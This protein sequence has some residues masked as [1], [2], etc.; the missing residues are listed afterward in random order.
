MTD[1]LLPD[2]APPRRIGLKSVIDGLKRSGT[3]FKKRNKRAERRE[4]ASVPTPLVSRQSPDTESVTDQFL[5]SLQR[6]QH[7]SVHR[8][9]WVRRVLEE[10]Q[11][12]G[13]N[14]TAAELVIQ[15]GFVSPSTVIETIQ[16]EGLQMPL[17]ADAARL[18]YLWPASLLAQMGVVPIRLHDETLYI[19]ALRPLE[20]FEQKT[21]ID[22]AASQETKITR[23]TV[24]P[25]DAVTVL[26][27]IQAT[28]HVTGSAFTDLLVR[29]DIATNPS[30]LAPVLDSLFTDAIE[31]ASSD[32]HIEVH[33]SATETR[34]EY[35]V[36][37][38]L[39]HRANI[40][41]ILGQRIA[42]LIRER[43][44]IDTSNLEKPHDGKFNV[45]FHGRPIDI[46]VA[47]MPTYAGQKLTLRLS[48]PRAFQTV[49]HIFGHFPEISA[50]L[51]RDAREAARRGSF[52][53]VTGPTNQGKSTTLR[54]VIM[55]MERES[56]R[57][58]E[59]GD[60]IEVLT[61][62]TTQTNINTHPDVGLTYASYLKHALRHDPDVLFVQELRDEDTAIELL[63][64]VETGH[65]A[66]S[67]LHAD[68]AIDTLPRLFSLIDRNRG[69]A[70]YIFAKFLTWIVHQ[71]LVSTPCPT[72]STQI[73]ASSLDPHTRKI[74]GLADNDTV[75]EI[76][77]DGCSDCRGLGVRG[78]TV[79]PE[80]IWVGPAAR[81]ALSQQ[82][83]GIISETRA[84]DYASLLSIPGLEYFPRVDF[85]K[86][87]AAKRVIGWQTAAFEIGKERV[88]AL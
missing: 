59:V 43:A 71:R 6:T 28:P 64:L 9:D 55:E 34:I 47:I 52:D 48:D 14:T 45:N 44:R 85:L 8:A 23:I 66:L 81:D 27:R 84:A 58:M 72:C 54:A 53:L 46:R 74:L 51:S 22:R 18:F 80:V 2:L 5:N 26:Q 50:R 73:T 33:D 10:H 63:R 70:A 39:M 88:Y 19:A 41:P 3:R 60:P 83:S 17:P 42:T 82:L 4:P 24:E 86:S 62:L 11:V 32:I 31:H 69:Q 37:N 78:R 25:L 20:H 68:S 12:R 56:K 13:L 1:D 77:G 38:T 30:N 40:S 16:A 7:L 79:V 67:T 75:V 21:L 15:L 76:S 61:P 36:A 57:V 87:L 29:H 65:K 35:R 49:S